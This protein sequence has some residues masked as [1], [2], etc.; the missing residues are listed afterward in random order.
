[1]TKVILFQKHFFKDLSFSPIY[2][3]CFCILMLFMACKTPKPPFRPEASYNDM[4]DNK[5]SLINIPLKI[6]LNQLEALINRQLQGVLFEDSDLQDDGLLVRATKNDDIKINLSGDSILYQVPL[7]IWIK[8]STALAD[9]EATGALRINF[10]SIFAVDPDWTLHTVTQIS[11]HEW[12]QKPKASLGILSFPVES[13]ANRILRNSYKTIEIAIDNQVSQELNLK[14]LVND[15]W[16]ALQHPVLISEDYQAWLQVRPLNLGMTPLQVQDSFVIATLVAETYA[17]VAVGGF[18]LSYAPEPLPPFAFRT[19]A[20]KD[21]NLYLKTIIPYTEAEKLA[22]E[23]MVGE[24]FEQGKRKV[25][26][27]DIQLYAQNDKL[28]IDTKLSGSYNGDIFLTGVPVYD[29]NK[30]ILELADFD[31]ELKTQNFLHKSLSFLFKK[32]FKK[33]LSN[34]LEF[35]M[36]DYLTEIQDSVQSQLANYEIQP[37]IYLRGEV[38]KIEVSSTSLNRTGIVVSV[39]SKG[40]LELIVDHLENW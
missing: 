39:D 40:V 21:F 25:T 29:P 27:E 38:E 3:I 12:I 18:G 15:A 1:M 26:I 35:P 9:V 28:I 22:K 34:A 13:I 5:I 32:G 31:Y 4:V 20:N 2:Y 8:K 14:N 17:D 19:E 10:N 37:G 23:Q 30:K 11:G 24:T 7:N 33:R 6:N 16:E 36:E